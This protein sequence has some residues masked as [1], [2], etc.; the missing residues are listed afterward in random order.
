MRAKAIIVFLLM[1]A[2]GVVAFAARPDFGV[3]V[4]MDLSAPSRHDIYKVGAGAEVGAF[5]TFHFARNFFFE[6]GL[7]GFY[8]TMSANEDI[9]IN[10][11]Y[12]EGSASTFG[13]RIPLSVGYELPLQDGM[14]IG[15]ATGPWVNFNLSARQNILPNFGAP[16]PVPDQTINLFKHGWK[17]VDALWGFSLSMKFSGHYYVGVS[18]GVAFTPL[19]RFGVKDKVIRVHRNTVA[20]SLGYV[21]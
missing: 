11:Y 6:P 3:R 8:N 17:R 18:G 1:A 4:G 13:L 5:G 19:A 21:F 20:V 10:G 9:E 7:V 2:S 15:F 14:V 12:Y 16:V